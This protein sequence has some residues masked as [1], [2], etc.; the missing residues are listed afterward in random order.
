MTTET[1]P[2]SIAEFYFDC[3]RKGDPEPLRRFLHPDVTFD[4][5]RGSTR[6]ADEFI[7]AVRVTFDPRPMFA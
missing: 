6:G 1:T 4:G 7:V 2:E 5:A 3:W